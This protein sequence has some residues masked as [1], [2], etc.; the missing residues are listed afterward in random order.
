MRLLLFSNSTNTGEEYLNFTL[1][2]IHD[3]VKNENKPA[4]FI[5]YAGISVGYD[6]YYERVEHELNKIGIKLISIHRQTDQQSAIRKA[7]II[8]IGGGN[9]FCLLKTL[10]DLKLLKLIKNNVLNGTLYIGWSAGSNIACPSIKTTNDMPIVQPH[11]FEALNLIPFQINPHY[12]DEMLANHSGESRETRINE[13]LIVNPGTHVI[14]LR[15]GSLLEVNSNKINL[16]GKKTCRLFRFG[17]DP[18][19]ILPGTDLK[20]FI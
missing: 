11:Q 5:P 17:K 10:I 16:L 15:E 1:P 9:T 8:I 19:E 3:F 14:G 4:L 2:Y 13:Y 20:L 12:T 18:I 7:E 6:N